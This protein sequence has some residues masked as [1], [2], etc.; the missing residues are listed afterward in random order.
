MRAWLQATRPPSQLYLFFSVLWGQAYAFYQT[1]SYAFRESLLLFVYALFCQL[2]IVF[3]N[4]YADMKTDAIN[5]HASWFS[6]GSGVLHQGL[7]SPRAL[8]R[9]AVL[10][11]LFFMLMGL[12]FSYLKESLW[13]LLLSGVS[14]FLLYLHS[15][16]PFQLAWKGGGELLQA[17]GLGLILP[18][19]SYLIQGGRDPNLFW[20]AP[21][22]LT[23]LA[24]A[25]ATTF[26]DEDSDRMSGKHTLLVRTGPVCIS[27]LMM[28]CQLATLGL[29]WILCCQASLPISGLFVPS[30]VILGL[31]L[32][33]RYFCSVRAG[34]RIMN[35][36]VFLLI[37]CTFSQL[38]LMIFVFIS[39][40]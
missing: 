2:M 13:P 36:R 35:L 22:F 31:T 38:S 18:L 39:Y 26:P 32:L 28:L 14:V 1:G 30:F 11:G 21:L 9:A 20:F 10:S 15:F 29:F 6:G 17:T 12:L 7:I 16:S 23:Q 33:D 8:F 24:C 37:L 4:D 40:A 27:V 3:A 5:C 34:N 25:L 19:S